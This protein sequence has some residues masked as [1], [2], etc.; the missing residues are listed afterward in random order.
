M[1]TD[2][3][4]TADF[5][6]ASAAQRALT[7]SKSHMQR[8]YYTRDEAAAAAAGEEAG[9]AFRAAEMLHDLRLLGAIRPGY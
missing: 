8:D 7:A 6:A 2:Y 1:T 9:L 4:L 5:A 3:K